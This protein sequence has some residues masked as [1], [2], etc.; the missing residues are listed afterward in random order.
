MLSFTSLPSGVR[1][2]CFA[3]LSGGQARSSLQ[4]EDDYRHYALAASFPTANAMGVYKFAQARRFSS[5]LQTR[6]AEPQLTFSC[7]KRTESVLCRKL[8]TAPE[9]P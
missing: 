8:F 3:F 4:M 6:Q 2:P 5:L 9:A 7:A 1:I